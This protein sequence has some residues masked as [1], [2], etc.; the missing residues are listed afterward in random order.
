M[1]HVDVKVSQTSPQGSGTL[2][3]WDRHHWLC[4]Q[5]QFYRAT[6]ARP[7]LARVELWRVG[8]GREGH[9]LAVANFSR[10][11]GGY[12]LNDPFTVST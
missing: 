7:C 10:G 8:K 1:S 12:T 3:Q 11:C 9:W 6:L 5:E 2:Q 4:T